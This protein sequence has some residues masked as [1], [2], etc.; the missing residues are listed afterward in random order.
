MNP[1]D[2]KRGI[3]LAVDAVV[4][5]LKKRVEEGAVVRGDRPG[6]HHLRQRRQGDRQDDRRGDAE[7]RQG[8]RD[9][10]RGGQGRSSPSSTSSR[11][12]SSTAAISRPTSSPTPRRWSPSSRTP[13]S[14]IHEKKLSTLQPLL[15]LLEAV[16]QAGKPLLIIAEDIEGEALA[17]LVV[18]KLRGGLKVAAVKAP[19]FGDRRKAMLE[20]IA[21]LT[22]GQR[23]LRRPRHQARERDARDAR[24]R[25]AG[26]D[27]QGQ[28]DDHRRRRQEEGHRGPHQRRSRRRSRRPPPTTTRRSCRSGWPSSPAASR[29]SASAAPPRSRSRRGRTGSTTRSTPPARRSRK[30]SFPA[31]ASRCCAPRRVG[32]LKRRT[33]TRRPVRHQHRPARARGADPPD[34]R[35]CRRRRLD[36]RRQDPREQV[37]DLRLRRADRANMSTC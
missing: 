12:C 34:R 33:T 9:H 17:T 4:E 25:Q 10:G 27:R 35:E 1:M 32:K 20:D 6:R 11:A 28:H 8:R 13:T 22:G 24:P 37:A 5:D 23:D 36:R 26:R 29:S 31:A 19:G 16:V 2:L 18:N 15:P 14:C 21:I 30:A 7:G 3:D